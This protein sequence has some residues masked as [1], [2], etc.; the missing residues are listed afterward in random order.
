MRVISGT[1]RGLKLKSP[2]GLGTR[3]TLDRVK[4][5]LFSMLF[6]RTAD[7]C[8]LDLFAGSGALGIEALSRG[9]AHCTFVDKNKEALD[10]VRQNVEKGWLSDRSSII[11]SDSIEYL[12]TAGSGFDIIFLDPPYEAGLYGELLCTIR[13]KNLLNGGGV[14]VLECGR[15]FVP[16]CTGF[17]VLKN[18]TYGKA[19]LFVL[20]ADGTQ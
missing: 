13:R 11:L 20:E 4:E 18:K 10:I 5:A 3:P 17:S 8:V 9:A 7:A 6:S 12:N 15:D 1:L 2:E 14:A 16:D 19:Q